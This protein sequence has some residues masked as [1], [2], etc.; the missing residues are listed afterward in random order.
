[1]I[2][3]PA[4]FRAELVQTAKAIVA[5]G[6]GILAADEST[7]TI[8]KRFAGI[9]VENVEENRRA[10]RELLF[11]CAKQLNKH[12]GGVILFEETLNQQTADGVPF[13]KLLAD[14]GIVVG[15]KVDK[16]TVVLP[17]TNGETTTQG[18][19][20]LAERCAQYYAKG[21]RFAKWRSVLK[22]DRNEPSQLAIDENANVLA[23]YA[24]VCQSQGL[25]PIVEPEIL[26]DG[27]HDLERAVF[28]AE[29]VLSAVYHK[30]NEHRVFLE[31]TLLKPAMVLPGQ[32]CPTKSNYSVADCALATVT[33]LQRTVPSAVPGI[34]FLSGGQS[35]EEATLNL[36]AINQ[37][38]GAKPWKLSFSYGRALQ[39]TVLKT[40]KGEAGNIAAAQQALLVR[41]QANSE[42]ACGKYTGG[43]ANAAA[44]ESTYVQ[45]YRY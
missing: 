12:I 9:G 15:I 38:P 14:N 8:G 4:N 11:T 13:P 7:G 45:N 19:D 18:L 6:K 23:R 35:E 33:V 43:A 31:G 21:A 29:A 41:A 1:M 5:D 37:A 34:T 44:L 30:L 25:V 39:H 32:N 28:V 22:I 3:A 10:Y 24:A 42:A 16:G 2:A 36:N 26:M 27:D 17:G 20:G 40:W